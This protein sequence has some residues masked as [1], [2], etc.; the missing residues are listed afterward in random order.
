MKL[1]AVAV[2]L[3]AA[4]CGPKPSTTTTPGSGEATVALPDVPFDKLDHEQRIEFMKQ[5]V[6]PT[7]KPLFVKHDAK[8]FADF[9]CPTCHGEPA[10]EGTFE[11]PNPA[12]PKLD[13]TK[14]DTLKKEDVDWMKN[15]VLP[16]MAKL[17]GE[18]V[19]NEA[20]P[21]G[22]NCFECHTQAGQ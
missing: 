13:F 15:E 6:V 17:I 7:M 11:M 14:L 10:K 16:T 18:P 12:L 20:N 9:G 1:F 3:A 4:A 19:A 22:F 21:D 5:K 2:V 8:E